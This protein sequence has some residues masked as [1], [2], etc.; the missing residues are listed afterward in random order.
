MVVWT[1]SEEGKEIFNFIS[2]KQLEFAR[3]REQYE[4]I[5]KLEK[6]SPENNELASRKARL[7]MEVSLLK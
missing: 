6:D 3:L 4:T 7:K 5:A 1:N 2:L